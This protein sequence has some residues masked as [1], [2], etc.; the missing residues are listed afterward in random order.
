MT[1]ERSET[2]AGSQKSKSSCDAK[3]GIDKDYQG[4]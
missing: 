4:D 2:K 1:H 3:H